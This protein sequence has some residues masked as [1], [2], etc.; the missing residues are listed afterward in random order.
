MKHVTV[1]PSP[2]GTRIFVNGEDISDHIARVELVAK[3]GEPWRVQLEC[4]A[5]IEAD[6]DAQFVTEVHRVCTSARAAGVSCDALELML[7]RRA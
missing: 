3:P 6:H 7:A 5:K 1:V 4:F 2:T